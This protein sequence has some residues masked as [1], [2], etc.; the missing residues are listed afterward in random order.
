LKKRKRES[1]KVTRVLNPGN[2]GGEEGEKKS[3]ANIGD[4]KIRFHKNT[5]E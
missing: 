2:R 5:F 3:R 4:C 1:K